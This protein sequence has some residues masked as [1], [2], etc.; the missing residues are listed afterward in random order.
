VLFSVFFWSYLWGILGAFIGVPVSIALL[1][2]CAQHP[3]SSWFSDL[4]GAPPKG[5]AAD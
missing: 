3:A 4:L 2:F 1:T 5:A